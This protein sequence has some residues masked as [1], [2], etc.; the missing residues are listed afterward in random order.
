MG[1]P[2]GSLLGKHIKLPTEASITTMAFA[3]MGLAVAFLASCLVLDS[4]T[5]G[6][7]QPG[8]TADDEETTSTA[9]P[10]SVITIRTI[11]S[12]PITTTSNTV[13]YLQ[14]LIEVLSRKVENLEDKLQGEIEGVQGD[15]TNVKGDITNVKSDIVDMQDKL[16]GE[17]EGVQEDLVNVQGDLVGVQGDITNVQGDITNVKGDITNVQGDITNVQ[18]NIVDM[19]NS[20]SALCGYQDTV[21]NGN[22]GLL[23]EIVV[24]NT[25]YFETNGASCSLDN[26]TGKFT[27]GKSGVYQVSVSSDGGYVEKQTYVNVYL[28]TSSGNYQDGNE[29]SIAYQQAG[30]TSYFYT[31][32]NA[33]R[34]ISLQQGETAW[35]GYEC[36][37][38]LTSPTCAIYN[39]KFCV[40]LYK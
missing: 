17:I 28:R 11:T 38:G 14:E 40:S 30:G 6:T 26:S 3:K 25:A 12:N 37:D 8:S 9:T 33:I 36:S 39:L 1:H 7:E 24:Y 10:T 15:I 18:G 22:S 2:L 31:P 32:L 4:L 5:T 35:L 21:G 16:K 29:A 20:N 19:Q 34:F 23:G 27:A 13:T